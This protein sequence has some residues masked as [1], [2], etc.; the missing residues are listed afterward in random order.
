M[1]A[2]RSQNYTRRGIILQASSH[3]SAAYHQGKVHPHRPWPIAVR[4]PSAARRSYAMSAGPARKA[5]LAELR[6]KNKS[7][8]G[9][10]NMRIE[11]RNAP[12]QR[13]CCT[14]KRHN[15][16]IN[17]AEKDQL[18]RQLRLYMREDIQKESNEPP[19]NTN[20]ESHLA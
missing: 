13:C 11:S 2:N 16:E 15:Q 4:T 6:L 17:T 18:A 14:R 10:S 5:S 19:T 20:S 8:I 9:P 12:L 1:S 3:G 7:T